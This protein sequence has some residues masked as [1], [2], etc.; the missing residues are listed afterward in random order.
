MTDSKTDSPMIF[1]VQQNWVFSPFSY[2]L[3]VSGAL[4]RKVVTVKLKTKIKNEVGRHGGR[5]GS[6]HGARRCSCV[7]CGCEVSAWRLLLGPPHWLKTCIQVLRQMLPLGVNS[8]RC[9]DYD[10]SW[11]PRL[12]LRDGAEGP[13]PAG[14]GWCPHE[15]WGSGPDSRRLP[16]KSCSTELA[17]RAS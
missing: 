17:K 8:K 14:S 5:H 7:W 1:W 2:S 15:T 13:S 4:S 3:L 16:W 12:G 6:K 10:P 11:G 9:V